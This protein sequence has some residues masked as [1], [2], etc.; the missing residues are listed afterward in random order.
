MEEKF[1][2]I[3]AYDTGSE[4]VG[5]YVYGLTNKG[6]LFGIGDYNAEWSEIDLPNFNK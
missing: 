3:V 1:I 5:G 2:Q 4:D 6:R